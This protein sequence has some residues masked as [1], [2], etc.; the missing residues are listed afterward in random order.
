MK[1]KISKILFAALFVILV[2]AVAVSV[3]FTIICFNDI[4]EL[5]AELTEKDDEENKNVD[6]ENVLIGGQYQILSTKN[7]SDAYISGDTSG[8]NEE[9][10]KTLEVATAILDEIITDDMSNYEKEK[11]I[12]N[13]I[14]DN[15]K[16]DEGGTVAVP[17]AR[18]ITDRPYGVLQNKQSVCVGFAT[19]FRLLTNM[20]GLDCMVMHDTNNS[21]AWNLI[22]L[23]DSCWYIVDCYSDAENYSPRYSHFNMNSTMAM[24]VLDWDASL[25]PVANGAEY[26]YMIMNMVTLETPT[27]LIEKIQELYEGGIHLGYFEI[28]YDEN[29]VNESAVYYITDGIYNRIEQDDFYIDFSIMNLDPESI[30]VVY[31]YIELDYGDAEIPDYDIPE[32]DYE[33]IDKQLDEIFGEEYFGEEYFGEEYFGEEYFGEE[34]LEKEYVEDDLLGEEF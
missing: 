13:W 4:K 10:R 21:H 29:G 30:V 18:G 19:S 26:N 22:K 28:P 23:D 27:D 24:N 32:F 1:T 6:N 2:A 33:K 9:D 5:K 17:E 11:A 8:L 12:Y 34:Y 25:Y 14:C 16:H 31:N 7:I 20:V 15:I 3:T